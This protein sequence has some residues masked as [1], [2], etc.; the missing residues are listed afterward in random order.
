MIKTL[1]IKEL[2]ESAG[3]VAL[4]ALGMTWVLMVCMGHNPVMKAAGYY[5]LS[6]HTAF[7]G[8]G[9]YDRAA[10]V[11][12]AL[13]VLLGLK[14]SAWEVH[15]NT[16][17]FLCHRPRARRRILVTKLGVGVLL[18]FGLL[19]AAILIYGSW[20]ATPGHL[21][22]PFEWSMTADCWQLAATLPL[23]YLGGF[24]SGIRPGRWFGTRLI[25]V[26]A[27]AVWALIVTAM[28]LFWWLEWPLL[29]LGYA[30]GLLAI[31]YYA[32]TRDY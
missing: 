19:A 26:A 7:L 9:F 28:V 21:S 4:A 27:A 24:L 5:D 31:D 11:G 6:N 20:A 14:Q 10:I 12:G 23:V 32:Q 1:A 13:A 25:P 15:H 29:V 30:C 22:A 18:T 2:R 8:D 3:L 16:V 17:H